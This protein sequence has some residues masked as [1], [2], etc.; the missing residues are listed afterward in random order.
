[1][2]RI[3]YEY[4]RALIT[5]I[6]LGG[7]SMNTLRTLLYTA[8]A[9]NRLV[10]RS[11]EVGNGEVRVEFEDPFD[12]ELNMA[13]TEGYIHG[14]VNTALSKTHITRISRVGNTYVTVARPYG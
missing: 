9:Y 2:Y 8:T 12:E 1:M 3:G 7:D 11:L 10:F 5:E 14:L 13:F 4:A 6:P